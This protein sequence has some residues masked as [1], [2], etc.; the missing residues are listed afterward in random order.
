MKKIKKVNDYLTPLLINAPASWALIRA[1][2][3]RALDSVD[4]KAPV[5]DVGCGDGFVAR[6]ILSKRKIKQFDVG[7]DLSPR[8]IKKAIKSGVYRE[9][10]VA[11]VY[12]LPFK[13]EIFNT[14]FSNSVVEHLPNLD[15]AL[16]EMSRVLKKNGELII[17]VPSIYLENY[18]IGGKIFGKGY[19][20]FFNKLIKHYNLYD[21]KQWE[22]ILLKY[23][24]K[25]INHHYYHTP[26]MIRIHEVLAYLAMPAHIAKVFV[27]YWPVFPKLRKKIVI[28][29]LDKLLRPFYLADVSKQEGG[30]VLLIAKKMS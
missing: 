11:S 29:W 5:L 8:E 12:D 24:L 23:D 10:I 3:I 26:G 13:N 14:V 27:G 25:L 19:N 1:N 28:P 9:C 18:L 17:T 7:I 21:H 22:K 6:I 4:F 16:K 2:E 30:S 20:K 15:L